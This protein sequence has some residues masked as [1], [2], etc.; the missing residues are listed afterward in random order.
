MIV[1]IVF[2][3]MPVI[4][5][6]RSREDDDSDDDMNVKIRKPQLTSPSRSIQQSPK[7]QPEL[8]IKSFTPRSP[9]TLQNVFQKIRKGDGK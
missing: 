8:K 3:P 4:G 2:H 7:S 9:H 1:L 5:F 6:V